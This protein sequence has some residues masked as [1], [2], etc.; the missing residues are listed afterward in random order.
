[1]GCAY[2]LHDYC[3][4]KVINGVLHRQWTYRNCDAYPCKAPECV[5]RTW[6]HGDG[7]HSCSLC[8][9]VADHLCDYPM[10]D[11][12]TCDARLCVDHRRQMGG[13]AQDI[14]FCPAHEVIARL[15]EAR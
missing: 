9:R 2:E 14:D 1:M 11:G 4:N 6:M 15:Q 8:G 13:D 10:G 7:I 12:K 5:F 3:A